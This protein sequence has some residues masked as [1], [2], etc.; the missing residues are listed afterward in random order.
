MKDNIWFLDQ[1][2]LFDVR[3]KFSKHRSGMNTARSMLLC[4]SLHLLFRKNMYQCLFYLF[5]MT[6]LLI[7]LS[8]F[9]FRYFNKKPQKKNDT[10]NDDEKVKKKKHLKIEKKKQWT[11]LALLTFPLMSAWT[12]IT[13]AAWW[14]SCISPGNGCPR[15]GSNQTKSP[16]D[17]SILVSI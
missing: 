16:S 1:Y 4:S 9:L 12:M 5:K 3:S 7:S 10:F 6:H 11:K 2:S 8:S 14:T 13:W 17:H 15:F